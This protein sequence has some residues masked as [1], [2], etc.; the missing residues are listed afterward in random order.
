LKL[1]VYTQF[2]CGTA[3]YTQTFS[4][5]NSNVSLGNLTIPNSTAH[6]ANVSGTVTDCNNAAVS[7][8]YIIMLKNNQYYRYN[9]SSNGSFNFSNIL[10]DDNS[11]SVTFIAED[12]SSNQQSAPF[13]FTIN[14]GA[15]TVPNLQACG[16]T[17]EEFINLNINGTS[18]NY[19]SPVDSFN[20][21]LYQQSNPVSLY[22][23][24]THIT[25]SG[26]ST[27][28]NQTSFQISQTNIAAGSTQ[29]LMNLYTSHAGNDST[30]ITSPIN[31]QIT[32]FGTVGQFIAG[33]F[34]GTLIGGAPTNTIYNTSCTF[35]IRRT[36]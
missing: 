26:G 8:G 28:Y 10:C 12:N 23:G 35:R 5:T 34:S 16:T 30:S 11:E 3:A 1:D 7:N 22:L 14:T 21:W 20:Y 31:V 27:V 17:T 29:Q 9:L 33:N 2:D 36:Q 18:Y 4:T 13:T 32:E 25:Q 6:T 15:N 19:S 24:S